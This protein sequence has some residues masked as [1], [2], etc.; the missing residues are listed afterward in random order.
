MSELNQFQSHLHVSLIVL[1][2][3]FVFM[4]KKMQR[5]ENDDNFIIQYFNSATSLLQDALECLNIP[6]SG[7]LTDNYIRQQ[8]R[9]TIQRFIDNNSIIQLYD[10]NKKYRNYHG[11]KG[12]WIED[13][14]CVNFRKLPIEEF[15]VFVPIF[16]PWYY[17]FKSYNSRRKYSQFLRQLI[18]HFKPYLLYFTVSSNDYGAEGFPHKIFPSNFLQANQAGTG[19]MV[20]PMHLKDKP[21]DINRDYNKIEY[22]ML[23]MGRLWTNFQRRFITNYFDAH[24]N[25][26]RFCYNKSPNWTQIYSKSKTILCPRGLGRNTYRLT[27][28]LQLGYIPVYIYDDFMWLPYFNSI[29][30][31]KIGLIARIDPSKNISEMSKIIMFA[32]SLT[33]DRIKEMSNY[34]ISL[35][36]T[37]FTF[38]ATINQIKLFLKF[39]FE[40]SDL[41]CVKH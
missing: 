41:R 12:P 18:G 33:I 39:G 28:T 36:D 16:I 11:Y 31:E 9:D 2:F 3:Y 19:N 14:W 22:D 25:E 10:P 8:E 24:P 40:K 32:N 38:N 23:F 20:L 5:G 15:G 29:H 17:T 13:C 1:T 27:E 30:W 26:T 21:A 6:N 4:Y 7:F 34:I 35:H 37:H